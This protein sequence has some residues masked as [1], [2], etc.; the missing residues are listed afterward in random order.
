MRGYSSVFAD[1]GISL[2]PA[3][4]P[5]G[6]SNVLKTEWPFVSLRSLSVLKTSEASKK[7]WITIKMKKAFKGMEELKQEVAAMNAMPDGFEKQKTFSKIILKAQHFKKEYLENGGDLS[8][9]SDP[10]NASTALQAPNG[11]PTI[12]TP[13]VSSATPLSPVKAPSK[14][15][16]PEG[17]SPGHVDQALTQNHNL[18]VDYYLAREKLGLDHPDT[19]AAYAEWQK[20]KDFLKKGEGFDS[21]SAATKSKQAASDKI[22]YEKL[23]QSKA[24]EAK[25]NALKSVS[26]KAYL[27][28]YSQALNPDSPEAKSASIS[29]LDSQALAQKYGLTESEVQTAM[30]EAHAKALK[31]VDSQKALKK[32]LTGASASVLEYHDKTTFE[33]LSKHSSDSSTSDYAMNA[34]ALTDAMTPE[35]K[36][37]VH[38]YAAS[39][40]TAQNKAVAAGK[41]KHNTSALESLLA[42]SALPVD[43][44][45]RRNMPQKWFWK[46]LGIEEKDMYGMTD[47]QLASH[48]GKVFTETAFSSTSKDPSFSSAFGKTA[49]ASGKLQLNIRAPKGSEGLDISYEVHNHG[50]AEVLLNKGAM[51]VIRNLKSRTH[52]QKGGFHYEVDVDLVGFKKD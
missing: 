9:L 34:K 44:K 52:S 21:S 26:E 12:T 13:P 15:V 48:V 6:L 45:L 3:P 35:Q 27:S 39:G 50:E 5:M 18:G 37:A 42:K 28:T 4:A 36:A 24:A 41:T 2:V 10:L 1:R 11:V 40:Y 23:Q 43:A 51:Y 38:D 46:A 14:W 25:T 8:K 31:A 16:E 47:E 29:S 32:M 33:D 49:H 22:Q 30:K 7:A 17:Y 19:K 20:S